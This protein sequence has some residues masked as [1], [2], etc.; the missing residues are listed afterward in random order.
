MKDR[1]CPILGYEASYCCKSE[2]MGEAL[3]GWT[4]TCE[5]LEG[6]KPPQGQTVCEQGQQF[7]TSRTGNCGR[8]KTEPY[9]CSAGV[10]LGKLSCHWNLGRSSIGN[11]GS[12][13]ECGAN[14]ADMGRH[15]GA[16]ASAPASSPLPRRLD[17]GRAGATGRS[18]PS[19]CSLGS[20]ATETP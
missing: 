8:G 1:A 7:V 2:Q 9:C 3:C 17:R 15:E 6:G 16:G 19:T 10:D 5:T 13:D 14:E 12:Y 18:G 20:A 11:S 4:G